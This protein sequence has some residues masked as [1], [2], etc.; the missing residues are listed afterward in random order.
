MPLLLDAI[1]RYGEGAR[2]L[3]EAIVRFSTQFGVQ[4]NLSRAIAFQESSFNPGPPRGSK[5]EIGPFQI[6]P[7]TASYV[8]AIPSAP[9]VVRLADV[10]SIEGN[11]AIGIYYL[12]M[13][14]DRFGDM[15]K[16]V[17]AYNAGPT[18]VADLI[19]RYGEGYFQNLPR[20]TQ[21]YVQNVQ[22]LYAQLVAEERE[23]VGEPPSFPPSLVPTGFIESLRQIVDR[24]SAEFNVPRWIVALAL[25]AV[26]ALLIFQL[27]R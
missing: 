27:L 18:R 24:L 20:T 19:R 17:A 15:W 7:Q 12:K 13:N 26:A 1:R 5:G 23:P 3:D 9:D 22:R 11:A 2:A 8:K 4:P 14:L 21:T 25:A 6:L 10:Y 16:A